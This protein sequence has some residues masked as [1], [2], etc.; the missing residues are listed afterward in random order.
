MTK[1]YFSVISPVVLG[2][3]LLYIGFK[4]EAHKTE[5][6]AGFLW[7]N[8]PKETVPVKKEKHIPFSSLSWQQKDK[9]LRY[10][11]MEALHKA[12]ITHAVKDME[13]F[14]SLQHF[15][16]NEASVFSHNFQY[17]LLRKPD[18]DSTVKN[19]V[20]GIGEK[21]NESRYQTQIDKSIKHLT[22]AYGL[23][24]FYQGN[25]AYSQKQAHVLSDFA[26]FHGFS[27]IPVSVDGKR[28]ESLPQTRL[29]KGQAA[30]LNIRHFPSIV[31]VHPKSGDVLPVASGFVTQDYLTEQMMV[32]ATEIERQ[33]KGEGVLYD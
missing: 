11:T 18:F 5:R 32:I 15:W 7:Y 3:M 6:P 16:L 27:F 28:I 25:D 29:D 4:A 22:K 31:L 19:P 9:V 1:A 24:F 17:A 30:K 13:R 21:L 8:L 12:R 23:L 14:L 2:L 20:S 10:Y 26:R 33:V